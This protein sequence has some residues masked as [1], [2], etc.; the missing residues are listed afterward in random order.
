MLLNTA[1]AQVSCFAPAAAA[2]GAEGG[3]VPVGGLSAPLRERPFL[4]LFL[5]D[6]KKSDSQ[7]ASQLRPR[8]KLRHPAV[9]ISKTQYKDKKACLTHQGKTNPDPNVK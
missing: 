8:V 5:L 3:E 7:D 2:V 6:C 4:S 9:K 1:R